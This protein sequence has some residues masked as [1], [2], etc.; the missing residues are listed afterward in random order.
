MRASFPNSLRFNPN[1]L[2]FK[3]RKGFAGLAPSG[4]AGTQRCEP[5]PVATTKPRPLPTERILQNFLPL[6]RG[7][8]VPPRHPERVRI[9]RAFF[10]ARFRNSLPHPCS[11]ADDKSPAWL[12][13]KVFKILC[14]ATE[15]AR[16]CGPS[17][18]PK[19]KLRPLATGRDFGQ[20][21]YRQSLELGDPLL[22]FRL[23]ELV[24][25]RGAS[26]RALNGYSETVSIDRASS[27]AADN[28]ESRANRW[29]A[30]FGPSLGAATAPISPFSGGES[31]ASLA[32]SGEAG[33]RRRVRGPGLWRRFGCQT[34]NSELGKR[35]WFEL[36]TLPCASTFF[37]AIAQAA[38]VSVP[39]QRQR[40]KRQPRPGGQGSG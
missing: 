39:R 20:D 14:L 12:W 30:E 15:A 4:E 28:L 9:Q 7:R 19:I 34:F 26:W 33:A 24:L 17:P 16:R 35:N 32:V 2:R 5:S 6:N 40:E 37:S 10:C 29:R 38:I 36:S 23:R 22:F 31:F 11:I 1:S 27:P 21:I 18:V 25:F 8:W 13:R 3:G